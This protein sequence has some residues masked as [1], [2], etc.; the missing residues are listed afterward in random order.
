MNTTTA[1]CKPKENLSLYWLGAPRIEIDGHPVRLETQKAMALLAYLSLAEQPVPREALT[2]MLWP[3]FDQSH[4]FANLRRNLASLDKSLG[5][6]WIDANRS[7]IA[8][9][10]AGKLSIDIL[11]YFAMIQQTRE[12]CPPSRMPCRECLQRL[13]EAVRLYRGEFLSCLNFKDCNEFD[14]W[15]YFQR[16]EAAQEQARALRRLAEGYAFAGEME[17]AIRYARR[18]L[19]L[20]CL[21]EEAQR[22]LIQAYARIGQRGSALKQYDE[23]RKVLW[24]Q[25]GQPPE[26][27]TTALI[28]K[29]CS[30]R[31]EPKPFASFFPAAGYANGAAIEPIYGSC[32]ALT[33]QQFR[34]AHQEPL[35]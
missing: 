9:K 23:C 20:D 2:V 15:Q 4:A 12:H 18:W 13:E 24:E 10:I 17:K 30:V 7:T 6:R 8:L 35:A 3:E 22:F 34:L 21:N 27:E 29:I 28:E 33:M 5:Y 16:E 11:D 1:G 14:E 26:P 32:S 31:S 25:L 19:N